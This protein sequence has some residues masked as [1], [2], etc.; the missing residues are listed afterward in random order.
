MLSTNKNIDILKFITDYAN[1]DPES[2]NDFL[3]CLQIRI[4]T[5]KLFFEL[6]ASMFFS[7]NVG[8]WIEREGLADK[9]S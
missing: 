2:R 6:K 3:F 9:H 5:L 7:Q 8:R 4:R 1:V